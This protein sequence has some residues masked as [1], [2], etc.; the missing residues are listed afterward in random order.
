MSIQPK[1]S[2]ILTYEQALANM[3]KAGKMASFTIHWDDESDAL[4]VS[5]RAAVW[6]LQ[7]LE[8]V[9]EDHNPEALASGEALQVSYQYG[10]HKAV[11][12]TYCVYEIDGFLFGLL[13]YTRRKWRYAERQV[14]RAQQAKKGGLVA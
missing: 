11:L 1:G 6:F 8:G 5:L 12:G 7:N 2:V 10:T 13:A 9:A 3:V 14:K 4:P